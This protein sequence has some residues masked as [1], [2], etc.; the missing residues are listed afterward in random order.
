MLATGPFMQVTNNQV[1]E[2]FVKY[3]K[4]YFLEKM[5]NHRELVTG[6]A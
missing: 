6:R 1:Q 3:Q 5:Y 4:L 2:Y